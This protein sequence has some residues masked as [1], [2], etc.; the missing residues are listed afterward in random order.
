M[1]VLQFYGCIAFK[2]VRL[3]CFVLLCFIIEVQVCSCS[4][5]IPDDLLVFS[6]VS[7][8]LDQRCHLMTQAH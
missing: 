5:V 3:Q 4:D 1:F 7:Y 8:C 6:S 2:S